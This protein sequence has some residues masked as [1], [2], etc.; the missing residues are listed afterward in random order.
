MRQYLEAR[1]INGTNPQTIQDYLFVQWH[2]PG[3]I[4]SLLLIL[5]P[6]IVKTAVGQM[7]G[8]VIAPVAF[9]F[10]WVAYAVTALLSIVGGAYIHQQKKENFGFPQLTGHQMA[11]SCPTRTWPTPS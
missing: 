8:R 1:A 9:S 5:G 11:G 4:L 3:D 10:G 6:E 7:A 2:N